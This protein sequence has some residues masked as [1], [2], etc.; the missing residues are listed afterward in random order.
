MKIQKKNLILGALALASALGALSAQAATKVQCENIGRPPGYLLVQEK[1]LDG[2][3]PTG[4]SNTWA[5]P[6]NGLAI[7]FAPHLDDISPPYRVTQVNK[8]GANQVLSLTIREVTD[9]GRFCAIRP[10]PYNFFKVNGPFDSRCNT[11]GTSTLPNTWDLY[12][13][14]EPSIAVPSSGAAARLNVALS[15]R[16][17]ELGINYVVRTSA[18]LNGQVTTVNKPSLTGSNRY[19][20][21]DLAPT[22]VAQARQGASFIF[23]VEVFSGVT[24][25]AKSSTTATG[26]QLIGN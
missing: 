12:K 17:N 7:L 26:A 13:V 19:S 3:C 6:S 18:N 24:S 14:F 9:G 16:L 1:Q 8:N 25:I 11:S 21:S 5:T 10:V 23:E 22:L 15:S 4:R 2:S 20:L